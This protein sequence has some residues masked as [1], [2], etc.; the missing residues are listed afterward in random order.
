M[1]L[2]LEG[3]CV[4]TTGCQ[5]LLSLDK[6]CVRAD[7]LCAGDANRHVQQV[8]AIIEITPARRHGSVVRRKDDH[9]LSEKESDHHFVGACI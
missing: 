8:M 4:P 3:A 2:P 1:Q 6:G 5:E 9:Y 7:G